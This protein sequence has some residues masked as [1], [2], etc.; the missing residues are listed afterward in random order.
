MSGPETRIGRRFAKLKAEGRAGLVTFTTAGDPDYDTSVK[1]LDGIAEA[2][3]DLIEIGVPFSDPMAD[4]PAIQASS[5]RA[6]KAGMTLKK[7]LDM[8]AGF[9]KKDDDTPIILMGYYNPIYI[10]GVDQFL[11]DA[12]QAGVDGFI[13]V[14]LPPEEEQ[15][16]CL[17]AIQAGL[18]FIYLTAPTT[19]DERLP[20]VVEHASGFIYF[21]SILGITGTRA[22]NADD[23]AGHVGR[24]RQYSDLPVCV[25]FGIR[26]PEQ[27]AEIAKIADGVV[28]GSAFVDKITE[29]LGADGTIGPNTVDDV[30][31]LVRELAGG[32]R[33][34][35][36]GRGE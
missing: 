24:I 36:T 21:V 20:R 9:R 29:N 4:G 5:L 27:A 13:V 35:H 14:D 31:G 34:A 25:G 30:L 23:V 2:G 16:F 6:I 33:G 18:N 32:V 19:D 26:T 7:T 1:I 3:A 11:V 15:E 17:P 8:V 28:V 10:Y 12:K 22:A